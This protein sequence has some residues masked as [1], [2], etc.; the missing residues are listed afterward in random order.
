MYVL[1]FYYSWP[2]IRTNEMRENISANISFKIHIST[3]LNIF[4]V[5]PSNSGIAS[6]G[7]VVGYIT[8][9]WNT[10]FNSVII[11]YSYKSINQTF[12]SSKLP[13]KWTNAIIWSTIYAHYVKSQSLEAHHSKLQPTDFFRNKNNGNRVNLQFVINFFQIQD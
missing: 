1:C 3:Y 9:I 12:F 13:L 2:Y 7:A 5:L 6:S 4:A 10:I 11:I 8:G